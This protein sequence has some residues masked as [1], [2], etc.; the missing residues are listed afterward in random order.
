[1]TFAN[2]TDADA[3]AK[4]YGGRVLGFADIKPDMVDLRG[5]ALHDSQ[6]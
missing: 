6:M 3:F 5:G 4:E 2:R 1:M